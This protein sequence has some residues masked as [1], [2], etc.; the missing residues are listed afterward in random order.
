M[1]EAGKTAG[2]WRAG[3]RRVFRVRQRDG[4][5]LVACVPVAIV[6]LSQPPRS[7]WFL[8]AGVVLLA[9]VVSGLAFLLW[10]GRNASAGPPFWRRPPGVRAT[11]LLVCWGLLLA[12]SRPAFMAA[13]CVFLAIALWGIVALVIR[14]V[15]LPNDV[16]GS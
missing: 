1:T 11:V 2:R 15:R 6:A 10:S 8:A 5:D 16:I 14:I 4:W 3:L 9:V 7:V 12:M 13:A